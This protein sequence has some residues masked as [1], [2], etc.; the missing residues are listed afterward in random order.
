M[1]NVAETSGFSGKVAAIR[2]LAFTLQGAGRYDRDEYN[3][4]KKCVMTKRS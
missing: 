4:C 3:L 2:K 1:Y